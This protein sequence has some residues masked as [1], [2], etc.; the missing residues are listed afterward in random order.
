MLDQ[1][2]RML[3]LATLSI[4]MALA[5]GC[6]SK[7]KVLPH[8]TFWSDLQALC[9]KAY[10]GRVIED[11]TDSPTFRGSS[12]LLGFTGCT[13]DSVTMP[14]HVDGRPWA[15]LVI[16]R[17]GEE[18]TLKHLHESDHAGK[19][20][21]SG[22]GGST[23]G[24]GTENTQDFYADE[25]TITLNEDARDTVWTIELRAG[26]ILQ[27]AVR[28]EGSDRRFRAAFD[29]TRARPAPTVMPRG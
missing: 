5:T 24:T 9:G 20:T 25:F 23:R 6:A 21:P 17:D 15:T 19:D 2:P 13:D 27:Y 14:L 26:S 8:H 22:Y 16:T 1:L 29:L 28:R 4:G 10:P 11:T 7:P 12:L 18:L 3:V